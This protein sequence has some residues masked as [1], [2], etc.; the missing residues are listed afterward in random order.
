METE[1]KNITADARCKAHLDLW[2]H[3]NTL[4][5]GRIQTLIIVQ[6]AYFG[7]AFFTS[8]KSLRGLLWLAFVATV[9][10]TIALYVIC[11]TDRKVRNWHRQRLIEYGI[12]PTPPPL[13]RK[14][15]ID[16]RLPMTSWE[17]VNQVLVFGT[18][19]LA[20]V[21]VLRILGV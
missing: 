7:V 19:L 14:V 10:F 2:M 5:W 4:M 3:Q 13:F 9:I 8:E 17:H 18:C 16:Y 6:G 12:D 15:L 11:F 21:L 1:L 20:D